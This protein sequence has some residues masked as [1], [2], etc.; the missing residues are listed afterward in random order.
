MYKR[1]F[2]NVP[3]IRVIVLFPIDEVS[4]SQRK[5]MTT[6]TGNVRTVAIDGKFDDLSLIHIYVL[7]G[8]S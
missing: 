5:L 3:G 7:N 1:Q 4:M 2:H 6:L 8:M